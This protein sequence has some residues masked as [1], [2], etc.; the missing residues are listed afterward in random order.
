M[1]TSQLPRAATRA[2][3]LTDQASDRFSDTPYVPA[4]LGRGT[5]GVVE[6]AQRAQDETAALEQQL[7]LGREKEMHQMLLADLPRRAVGGRP[8]QVV[9]DGAELPV[10]V[11][12]AAGDP[13]QPARL[14]VELL[15]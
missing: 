5:L 7:D 14:M 8:C 4:L 2:H 12:F 1:R 10:G 13:D 9:M 6:I 15:D 3:R 11:E